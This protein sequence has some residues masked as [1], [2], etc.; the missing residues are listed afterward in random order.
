MYPNSEVQ[1]STVEASIDLSRCYKVSEIPQ[2]LFTKKKKG[3]GLTKYC[4][5]KKKKN[6][7]HAQRRKF[8]SSHHSMIPGAHLL[9][10]YLLS[11][12]FVK[13]NAILLQK[14]KQ[15]LH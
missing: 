4:R 15:K 2:A 14:D 13:E 10:V 11:Q 12:L 6:T 1:Y 3:G 7:Y 9:I 5:I 8:N